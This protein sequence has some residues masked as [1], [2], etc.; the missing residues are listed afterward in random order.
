M[1][2]PLRR[3]PSVV[4]A[5]VR[6]VRGAGNFL[7]TVTNETRT[8][9]SYVGSA[10]TTGVAGQKRDAADLRSHT[11]NSDHM[12]MTQVRRSLIAL[13][14]GLVCVM[15]CSEAP[16]QPP[17]DTV[18]VV[19]PP[20][21][22]AIVVMTGPGRI[23]VGRTAT[24]TATPQTTTGVT[25]PGKT[26]AWTTSNAAAVTVTA[27]GV[28]TAVAPGTATISAT[29]D[30]AVGTVAVIS[31]DASLVTLALTGNTGPLALGSSVQFTAA[32]KDSANQAVALRALTWMSSNPSVLSV[33]STGRV[34]ANGVGTA[35]IS[36]EGVTVTAAMA[37]VNITVIPVPVVQVVIAP[38]ADTI[39]Q[40]SAPRTIVATARDSA[41]NVLQRPLTYRSS[42]VDVAV[43]D[44]AGL[45]S[46]TG[47]G[48][49]TIYASN[50]TKSDSV[51]LYVVPDSGYYV[52]TTG[53]TP[54]DPVSVAIDIPAAVGPAIRTGIIPADSV[55]RFTIV[56]SNGT[57]RARASTSA[58]PAR[59]PAALTGIALQIGIAATNKAVTLGPPSTVSVF[60]LKPY[61]ATISAPATVAINS[62]V[63]VTWTFDETAQP[64]SFFPDRAPTGRLLYS[65]TTG[66]DLSGTSVPATVTRDGAGLSTFSATFTAPSSAGTIHLQVAADGAVS[67][68]LY[69]IV[70]RGQAMRTITVQ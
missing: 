42:N 40:F 41:G 13:T 15:S 3:V 21:V 51:R 2:I 37:S 5:A 54:G 28:A 14:A 46:A 4:E 33:S 53:G 49:V 19:P 48:P 67:Q 39:L 34:T 27:A 61:T 45:A 23:T 64:F 9:L 62:T 38:V 7:Q 66:L 17:A 56:T 25:V 36:A 10:S 52:V 44:P 43:L 31:S 55:S 50:G 65:T 18:I 12:P 69:P 20:P 35:T 68:L 60:A 57:Y 63:T 32:G 24:Y 30:G 6:A 11:S 70:F 29:V 47:V 26:V 8:R 22:V 1:G 58:D 59:A 16:T